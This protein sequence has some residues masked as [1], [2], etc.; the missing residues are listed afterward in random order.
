MSLL[1]ELSVYTAVA[2]D[3]NTIVLYR[4]TFFTLITLAAWNNI[5]FATEATR[6]TGP[7]LQSTRH[8]NAC[9]SCPLAVL[10]AAVAP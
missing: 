10:T 4:E 2:V 7:A 8:A 9:H 3:G 5:S 6:C 1:F